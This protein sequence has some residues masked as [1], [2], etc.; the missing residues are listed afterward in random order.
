MLLCSYLILF[1]FSL[2]SP[3]TNAIKLT[4]FKYRTFVCHASKYCL[5]C[6]NVVHFADSVINVMLWTVN[7]TD[8]MEWCAFVRHTVRETE[9]KKPKAKTSFAVCFSWCVVCLCVLF[10]IFSKNFLLIIWEN[11]MSIG[12]Q[13]LKMFCILCYAFIPERKHQPQSYFEWM[14]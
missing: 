3:F 5:K 12:E 8:C 1:T 13:C 10:F 11:S 9:N 14:V 4:A 7:D 6:G 2:Y